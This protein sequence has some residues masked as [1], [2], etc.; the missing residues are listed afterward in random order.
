[1]SIHSDIENQNK[2]ALRKKSTKRKRSQ[3]KGN[4]KLIS[5][6]NEIKADRSNEA[7]YNYKYYR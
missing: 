3:A 7:K 6:N 4:P 2:R 5:R 1:M